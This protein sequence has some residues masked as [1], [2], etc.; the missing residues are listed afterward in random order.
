M[1]KLRMTLVLAAPCSNDA[2]P[3]PRWSADSV[4]SSESQKLS[5]ERALCAELTSAGAAAA[6]KDPQES[7]WGSSPRQSQ[8]HLCNLVR[9]R[10]SLER[11]LQL[12]ME[13]L[14][15]CDSD[16]TE[17]LARTI[18]V[19]QR[20]I[21]RASGLVLKLSLTPAMTGLPRANSASPGQP[22]SPVGLVKCWLR[23][24]AKEVDLVLNEYAEF[25][26]H[27][28]YMADCA[29][30]ASD[31]ASLHVPSNKFAGCEQEAA[32]QE[33]LV[34]L[35]HAVETLKKPSPC[36][37]AIFLAGCRISAALTL[38]RKLEKL[39]ATGIGADELEIQSEA[40]RGCLEQVCMGF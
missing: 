9:L 28:S 2:R 11:D 26:D 39:L 19:G 17:A 32:L 16:L 21:Q 3:D 36:F 30:V 40:L 23:E 8:S 33:A 27:V 4:L 10:V 6:H 5:A 22:S 20:L 38:S 25:A 18:A 15:V 13:L 12:A 35:Q 31:A 14:K 29:E 34:P 7:R 24:L 1:T 37:E